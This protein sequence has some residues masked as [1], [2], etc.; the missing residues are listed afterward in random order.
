MLKFLLEEKQAGVWEGKGK[1]TS[2]PSSSEMMSPFSLLL[3]LFIEL[4]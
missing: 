3:A 1:Q 2:E 4:L